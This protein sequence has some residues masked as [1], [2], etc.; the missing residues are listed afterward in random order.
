MQ[1]LTRMFEGSALLAL[2]S[3]TMTIATNIGKVNDHGLSTKLPYSRSCSM[4][5]RTRKQQKTLSASFSS[6]SYSLLQHRQWQTFKLQA[7][8]GGLLCSWILSKEL[9]DRNGLR[10]RGDSGSAVQMIPPILFQHF[11]SIRGLSAQSSLT[12]KKHPPH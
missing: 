12:K 11:W 8:N 7:R 2:C 10:R 5:P 6:T 1:A 9:E 4:L 3:F